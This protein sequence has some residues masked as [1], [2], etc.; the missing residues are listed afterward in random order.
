MSRSA[1]SHCSAALFTSCYE[2]RID[3]SHS[4]GLPQFYLCQAMIG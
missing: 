4:L 3:G 1:V 2:Q